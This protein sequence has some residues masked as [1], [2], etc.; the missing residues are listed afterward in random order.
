MALKVIRTVFMCTIFA[1]IGTS[2]I[3]L[4]D[5][6]EWKLFLKPYL[7]TGPILSKSTRP[8]EEFIIRASDCSQVPPES[9]DIITSLDGT[10]FLIQQFPLSGSIV[11][12]VILNVRGSTFESVRGI[13]LFINLSFEV[14]V[15]GEKEDD[16][17]FSDHSPMEITIPTGSGLSYLLGSCNFKRSDN[18]VCVYNSGGSFTIDGIVTKNFTSGMVVGITTL[19]HI[20]GGLGEDLG[21]PASSKPDTWKKI[22]LLFR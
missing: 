7:Q 9:Q 12:H 14:Y 15:N 10:K 2:S 21:F 16:V 17:T 13:T 4:S 8:G 18:L 1:F 3:A 6:I 5:M 20:V 11:I 22:K 19:S